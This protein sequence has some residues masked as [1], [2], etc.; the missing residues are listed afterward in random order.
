MGDKGH[1]GKLRPDDLAIALSPANADVNCL[2]AKQR[3]QLLAGM[4][5][6]GR[7]GDINYTTF[8]AA[9]LESERSLNE[10]ACRSAFNLL[11]LDGD[12]LLKPSEISLILQGIKKDDGDVDWQ[13]D[14]I[15]KA[16]SSTDPH[17]MEECRKIVDMYDL[18][19]N[20]ELNFSAF[21]RMLRGDTRG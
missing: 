2:F 9:M 21:V 12:G 18:D 5:E 1:F 10:A 7:K 8:L 20:G 17:I 4:R 3:S 14:N 11:D 13:L 16:I 6:D 15:V 19:H